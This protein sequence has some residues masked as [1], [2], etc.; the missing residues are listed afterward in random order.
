MNLNAEQ[1]RLMHQ[2]LHLALTAP[3][4]LTINVKVISTGSAPQRVTVDAFDDSG[5]LHCLDPDAAS[6]VCVWEPGHD[7]VLGL[8]PPP[9]VRLRE[10]RDRLLDLVA[11]HLTKTAVLVGRGHPATSNAVED[12]PRAKVRLTDGTTALGVQLSRH[13]LDDDGRGDRCTIRL[14]NGAVII[15]LASDVWL[16]DGAGGWCQVAPCRPQPAH[17]VTR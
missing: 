14:Q 8:R 10:L 16:D 4:G 2:I 13:Q 17:E 11:H 15:A 7:A 3:A 6:M 12:M 1:H 9:T 5:T